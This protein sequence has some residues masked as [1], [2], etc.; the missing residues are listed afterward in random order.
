MN[1]RHDPALLT[2]PQAAEVAGR[3]P[4][5]IRNWLKD[6]R[7]RKLLVVEVPSSFPLISHAALRR[8][9]DKE[10]AA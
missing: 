8:F 1:D 5:T 6:E 7:V 4:S 3:H 10:D 2:V 9:L